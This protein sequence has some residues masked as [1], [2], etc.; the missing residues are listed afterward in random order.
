MTTA[1]A[2]MPGIDRS[3]SRKEDS[4]CDST[5]RGG[6][7]PGK[8]TRFVYNPHQAFAPRVTFARRVGAPHS[9]ARIRRIARQHADLTHFALDVGDRN[10][11][12]TLTLCLVALA[13]CADSKNPTVAAA[14]RRPP[15]A[16][17]EPRRPRER[18]LIRGRSPSRSNPW[19][20]HASLASRCPPTASR[21]RA[22][23]CIRTS[24]CPTAAPWNGTRC[25]LHVHAIQ[26]L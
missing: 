13:A 5:A 21:C 12:T 4:I 17:I 14:L 1:S 6:G 8:V 16:T 26:E 15:D 3:P 22:K 10:A 11:L 9:R 24:R 20:A 2:M 19:F 25:W 18:S 7:G 23:P